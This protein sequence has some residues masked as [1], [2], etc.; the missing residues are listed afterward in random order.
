[1][2]FQKDE[3]ALLLA[4]VDQAIEKKRA[5]REKLMS[6][7]LAQIW[8]L[9]KTGAAKCAKAACCVGSGWACRLTTRP[10]SSQTQELL[11]F[12]Q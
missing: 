11:G 8:R 5:V 4:E 1:L 2:G 9:L 6:E 3:V 12:G 10:Y 7:I